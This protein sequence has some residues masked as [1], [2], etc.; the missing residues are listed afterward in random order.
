M[1]I[2]QKKNNRGIITLPFLLV[3]VII[4]F[5][6]LSFL[7]LSMTLT[8]VTITQYMT[9]SSA[10]KLSLAGISQSEQLGVAKIH[11]EKLRAQFFNPSAYTGTGD[12]FLIDPNIDDKRI[13]DAVQHFYENVGAEKNETRDPSFYGITAGFTPQA[14]NLKIP[15]LMEDGSAE[16][17]QPIA[18]SS[19]LGRE[20]SKEECNEFHK[21]RR[22]AIK[23]L[24]SSGCPHIEEPI[25]PEVTNGSLGD[26][27]C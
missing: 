2:K 22:G 23:A 19:F 6:S 20:P 8:H 17:T 1:M 3:L 11:Y 21:A 26:N 9:Y 4:L 15:F 10:R 13:E 5:F 14:L 25:L 18:I 24:C 12:W 7:M 27:G 16:I